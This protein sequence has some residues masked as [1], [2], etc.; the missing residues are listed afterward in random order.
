MAMQ[1]CKE[2][3]KRVSNT[4]K[5]CRYCGAKIKKR[6]SIGRIFAST[7][8]TIFFLIFVLPFIIRTIGLG[9]MLPA[10]TIVDKTVT[11]APDQYYFSSFQL[12][13]DGKVKVEL[14]NQSGLAL[15][16]YFFNQRQYEQ[17]EEQTKRAY[18]NPVRAPQI[19]FKAALSKE[20]LT[21]SHATGW[22]ELRKGTYHLIIEN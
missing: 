18:L 8:V 9:G 1:P 11:I 14:S 20:G 12:K 7:L 3:G 16:A 13:Y 17:W 15:D 2:C 4:K 5:T 21:S 6:L 19:G 22:V 10:Q